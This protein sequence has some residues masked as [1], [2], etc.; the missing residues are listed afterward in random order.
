M[1]Y[2]AHVIVLALVAMPAATHAQAPETRPGNP[3]ARLLN[4]RTELSLTA[5]QVRRLEE[6]DRR[7]SEQGLHLRTR[8]EA[9]RGAPMGQT[10][11]FRDMTPEQREQLAANRG[12]IE[13]LMAQLR[14]LHAQTI[15]DSR[16][17]LTVEQSDRARGMWY[18]GPGMGRGR[19][20]AGGPGA[21]RGF[22]PGMAPRIGPG[23]APGV[24]AG[25]R[26]F[27]RN[28]AAPAFRAPWLYPQARGWRG[29]GPGW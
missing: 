27:N 17:V 10:L 2:A 29:R 24:D 16:E 15:A 23:A 7:A 19:G 11:R 9:L 26:G 28:R 20:P 12:E 22:W 4:Y 3:A 21:G 18:G 14:A 13:P 8:L 1:R 25:W 5:D 6:I